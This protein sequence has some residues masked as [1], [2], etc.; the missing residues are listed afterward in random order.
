MGDDL[1]ACSG[2]LKGCSCRAHVAISQAHI[3]PRR[4]LGNERGDLSGLRRSSHGADFCFCLMLFNMDFI[5][6]CRRGLPASVIYSLNC[7]LG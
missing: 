5:P 7:W 2:F 1:L 3:L 6:R 4:S